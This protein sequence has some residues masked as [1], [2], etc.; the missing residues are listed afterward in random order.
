MQH[1]FRQLTQPENSGNNLSIILFAVVEVVMIVVGIVMANQLQ[2]QKEI[3]EVTERAE[4]LFEE[5]LRDL[6]ADCW[7]AFGPLMAN[8]RN[9]RL[10]DVIYNPGRT[11]A[12]VQAN[13]MDIYFMLRFEHALHIDTQGYE[14]LEKMHERLPEHLL[15][16][17]E[18]LDRLMDQNATIQE[19]NRRYRDMVYANMEYN[20]HNLPWWNNGTYAGVPDMDAVMW[21]MG[22]ECKA[23][24]HLVVNSS[25]HLAGAAERFRTS[26]IQVY[27]EIRNI[28]G[29]TTASPGY[30]STHFYPTERTQRM[31]GRFVL[32]DSLHFGAA[33]YKNLSMEIID[34]HLTAVY[35]NGDTLRLNRSGMAEYSH[36]GP[37]LEDYMEWD[38]KL[39]VGKWTIQK[40]W[41]YE[42]VSD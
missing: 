1:L 30:M 21:M 2:E 38:G 17:Y 11:L 33:Q 29:D 39:V 20:T 42:R 12:E 19:H 31:L 24:T 25:A 37:P 28:L 13:A 10:S 3:R 16:A 5:V 9:N 7:A 32:Q 26:A 22:E 34:D 8:R 6:E 15:E 41:T 18:Q 35:G 23:Q 36:P 14:A 27:K 40:D 4:V